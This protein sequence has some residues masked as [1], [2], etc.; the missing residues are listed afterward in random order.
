MGARDNDGYGMLAVKSERTAP[1]K[2]H[3]ISYCLA[4][5]ED[6]GSMFVCHSCDNPPCVN[7]AHLFLGTNA[8]NVA[9]ASAKGRLSSGDDHWM[10]RDPDG[11]W[12]GRREVYGAVK[13]SDGAVRDMRQRRRNGESLS[14]IAAAHGASK[15]NV[16]Q[17]TTGKTRAGVA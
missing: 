6:P 12:G 2:A 9:D 7:P 14:S 1:F 11:A 3:R 15:S 4:N 10:R 8:D 17:I 13:F 16:W 5:G